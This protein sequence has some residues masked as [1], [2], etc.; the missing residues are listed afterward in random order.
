VVEPT[1]EELLDRAVHALNRGDAATAKK[2]AAKVL[3]VDRDN[4]EAEDVLAARAGRNE[5]RRLTIMFADVVDS[6]A[7]STRIEPETYFTVIGRYRHQVTAIADR[8]EGHIF[9]TK[10]DG[11]LAV[12][13]HPRAHANDVHRAVRAG[14]DITR[15]VAKLSEQARERFGFEISVRVGVHRGLVYLDTA[16]D[17]VYGLGAN[18]AARVSGLAPPGTVVV[19]GAIE[20]LVRD[21]FELEAQPAQTV[22]GIEG[23]I[24]HY[25]VI[26]ERSTPARAQRGP[27]VGRNDEL[28]C[29]REAWTR[30]VEGTLE[31]QGVAFFGE[32]GMG[33]S[34]LA[35]AA[36]D[37]AVESGLPVLALI[38]S[39]FHTEAGLHPIRSLLESRCGID[40]VT[41][42]VERVRLLRAEVEARGLDPDTAIPL[43]APVLGLAAEHGYTP[44]PAQGQKLY[45]QIVE[46]IANY[47]LSCFGDGA[48]VM[49]V[50]DLQW[51]DA[52]TIDVV[53]ALL[54]ANSPRL[55]MVLTSRDSDSIPAVPN[56]SRFELAPFTAEETR[57]LVAAL[58]PKLSATQ[59]ADIARRCDG[60]P[61][62]I[63]EIVTK[64]RE[65]PS[66]AAR[67]QSVPDTLYEALFARL[68]ASDNA[69]PVVQAAATIGRDFD[70]KLLSSIVKLPDHEFDD[71]IRKLESALVFEPS[72]RDHWRFRHELL[73][74]VAYELPPPSVRRALHAEVADA[75]VGSSG[76][77]ASDWRLVAF[78]YDLADR[79]DGAAMAY[80]LA[81]ADA[82]RRGALDESR[83]NLTNAL[84]QVER[85][86][87]GPARSRTEVKLRLRRGFLASAAEGTASSQAAA[88]F[89]RCVELGGADLPPADL[90]ASLTALWAYYLPRGDIHRAVEMSHSV[91]GILNEV[92]QWFQ[93]YTQAG[94]GMVAW[95]QGEF[96]SARAFLEDSADVLSDVDV[97]VL[98]A[99]WFV[100]N[101]PIAST[102]TH[103]AL[104]RVA[105]GDFHGAEAE[106]AEA[107]RRAAELNFP[108]GPFSHAYSQCYEVWM[109]LEAGQLDSAST[110]IAELAA[111]AEDHQFDSFAFIA[112]TEQAAA[113][114]LASI[115][116]EHVEPAELQAHI[117]TMTMLVDAWRALEAKLF[118][119]FYDGVLARLLI[120]AGQ[121][122]EAR[123][124]VAIALQLAEETGALF[125]QAELLRL[126]AHTTEDTEARVADLASAIQTARRQRAHIFELRSAID[127]FE[128]RGA[129]ARQAL[130]DAA[131]RLPSDGGWP[132]LAR[133]RALLG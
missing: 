84:A 21:H 34:R 122:D 38:G 70:R 133:A 61:L 24:E 26:G 25:L 90:F 127:D 118:V 102:H 6:T 121:L 48:G 33:K 126:R 36:A 43:L 44:V 49:L 64:I 42:K 112:A 100:P 119:N 87:P 31:T 95:Y 50:E 131:D 91:G 55:L 68:R 125:Y 37:F 116:R 82:R 105:Q 13:G 30:A 51:F 22:K 20:R 123:E 132:E 115:A 104:A 65:Q 63:E 60:V 76:D 5:L 9:S 14:L 120:A 45:E 7:L 74:E 117:A 113:A 47:L 17:D 73:R 10:G 15:E 77:D 109:R 83:R 8:Y 130:V 72:G 78:H 129:A 128:L 46:A 92:G 79:V 40:R 1:I 62:Y 80:Q 86:P 88:D 110:T 75:L 85:Q 114:A 98:D 16:E 12:F 56:I 99:L 94:F 39:V 89:E 54:N 67:W 57:H 66:D 101:E 59:R 93:P 19:S 69:I 2:L 35:T 32:P 27:L 106:F 103:L 23:P 29:L 58:D 97:D 107:R 81:A 124:R 96:A 108:Q 28:Q 18:L 3:A 41:E 52:S 53:T 4:P 11:L 111:L 71:A